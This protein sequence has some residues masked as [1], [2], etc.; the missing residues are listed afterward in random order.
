MKASYDRIAGQSVERL[1]ALSDGVFAVAMTLL[2]LDLHVPAVAAVTSDHDLW[3]ALVVLGPR[4]VMYLMSFLTLGI[5]W[6]AQQTQL[7]CL[8]RSDRHLIWIHMAFLFAVSILPFSTRLLAEFPAFRV[9]L[10]AYWGESGAIGWSAL[11][12]LVPR[13]KGRIAERNRA[14]RC[15]GDLQADRHGTGT[16]C[17]GCVA[18]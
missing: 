11:R 17:S 15:G 4:F 2:V 3:G 10:L 9:A 6:V 14:V 1:A 12:K 8:A 7:N 13:D 16:L 5:F 18:L